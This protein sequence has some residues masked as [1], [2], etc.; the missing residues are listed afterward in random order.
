[1]PSASP[2]QECDSNSHHMIVRLEASI[3]PTGLTSHTFC[4]ERKGSGHAATC[5]Q[6]SVSY[7]LI[8]LF[9]NC[10]PR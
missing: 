2:C 6:M 9:D 10:V 8:M 3:A 1:M 5:L 7:Y 4:R